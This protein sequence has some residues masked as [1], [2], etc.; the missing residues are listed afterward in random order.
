M[1]KLVVWLLLHVHRRHHQPQCC[2]ASPST[3]S[4]CCCCCRLSCQYCCCCYT[5]LISRSVHSQLPGSRQHTIVANMPLCQAPLLLLLT[6]EGCCTAITA[7]VAYSASL[8]YLNCEKLEV[9]RS[10]HS[11]WCSQ[12]A[13]GQRYN[14]LHKLKMLLLRACLI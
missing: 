11:D 1:C 12:L 2:P 5:W 9:R 10:G 14:M 13:T 8:V 3:I 4:C 6:G 7:A